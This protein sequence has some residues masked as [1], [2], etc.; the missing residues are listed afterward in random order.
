MEN[1]GDR[2]ITLRDGRALGWAEFGDRQGRPLFYFHGF[3]ASRLEAALTDVAAARLGIRII[4]PDRPGFGLSDVQPGRRLGDW[5]ADVTQLADALGLPRFAVL[6]VSGGGPYALACAAKIPQRLTAVA[7]V[8]GLGP[9]MDAGST[10][11]MAALNRFFLSLFR[12]SQALGR[13]L[14]SLLGA[15]IR[16]R[17]ELFFGLF[18]ATV[19]HVDR[20]ALMAP[21]IQPL[22]HASMREAFRQGSRGAA[23]ELALYARPWDFN[24]AAIALLVDL[25]HGELDV[26]VPPRM[27]ELLSKGIPRCRRHTL[28]GEGHFSLPLQR[29]E[30]ILRSLLPG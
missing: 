6:G 12:H 4:A 16:R 13:P 21:G 7:I 23:C 28:A 17:P 18:T 26:T 11:G 29:M 20:T 10:T 30:D 3:P 2:R 19:P 14:L 9:T 8:G 15:G 5:P 1:A 27:G 22:F 24:L 25:W